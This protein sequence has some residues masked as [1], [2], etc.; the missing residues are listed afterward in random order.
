[1]NFVKG[2]VQSFHRHQ[3]HVP[4]ELQQVLCLRQWSNQVVDVHIIKHKD[5][6]KPRGCF[7]EFATRSDLEKGLMKDG[8][9][10]TPPLCYAHYA[11]YAHPSR[12]LCIVLTAGFCLFSLVGRPCRLFLAG[13]FVLMW[14]R[15][16][17]IAHSALEVKTTLFTTS[18][19]SS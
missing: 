1:M 18:L 9:V 6:L 17:L 14:R 3:M 8:S 2:T 13:P 4:L 16:G 7:V 19:H 11:R 12:S 15:T 5:T 10:R